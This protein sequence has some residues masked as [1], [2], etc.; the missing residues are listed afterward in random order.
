MRMILGL[1]RRFLPSLPAVPPRYTKA[2]L[3]HLDQACRLP[4]HVLREALTEIEGPASTVESS[5]PTVL[6][7][8]AR[9]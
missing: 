3:A 2:D 7:V 9:R 5:G 1:L 6:P 4:P 8:E